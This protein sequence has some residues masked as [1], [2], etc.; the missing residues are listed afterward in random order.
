[1]QPGQASPQ[2]KLTPTDRA[3]GPVSPQTPSSSGSANPIPSINLPKGGGAIRGIGE[4]FTANPATGS[5][6]L[7]VPIHSSPGRSGFGPQ[8][9]LAYDSGN[10]NGPFGFGWSLA[11]PA[12]TRK[13]EKGLPRY[14]DSQE[15]DTFIL[16]GAEDLAPALNEAAGQ[17]SRDTTPSRTIYSR[18]YA[19]HRYRPRVEGLFARIERWI[20]VLDPQDTF[21]RS[22]SKDNITT[23]YGKTPASRIADPADASR[24]FSWLICESYDDKG[25]ATVF[26]Y[27]AENS[28]GVDLS[29]AHERNRS[30][31]T[32]ASKRYIKHVLYGNRTPYFPDLNAVGPVALPTDWCFE[33]VFDYG[34]H[35]L[36][37]PVPQEKAQLWNC[38][39]DPFSTYKA[40]FEVR[41]YRLCRRVLLFHHF[42]AEANVGLNCLVRSTDLVHSPPSPPADPSQPFYSYLLSVTQTGYSRDGAGG[43]LSN[44]L[45][46]LELQYTTAEVNETVRE[47]DAASLQNFPAGADG[48]HYRW[49]DLDGEGSPGILTEQGA[50]WYYKANLSPVNQ[51]TIGGVEVTLP[52]F[53]PVQRIAL[54]PSLADLTG[55][56]QQLLD[57][58]GDGVADLVSFEGPTPGFYE[59]TQDESWEAFVAFPSVP[60]VDWRSPNLKFVDLTG[61]GFPDLLIG[62][63]HAFSW[64]A[65]LA[66]GGFGPAQRT[67]QAFD[68]EKGPKL[69]FADGSESIFLADI[70]GDGLTDLVR[71]RNGEVCYWPNLGYGRFGAKVA[72][73]GSPR[74]DRTDLFDGRRI[75]LADIDGSGTADIIYFASGRVDL[76][77]NQS[78]NGWGAKRSLSHFPQVESLSSAM[79]VDLLGNGTVC[80]VWS[81]P[82]SSNARRPLRYIDLM[83]GQ[84]PHLLARI[85]NN[86][87]GETVVRYA[88]STKSYV[89]D[90]L[91]GTPWVTR[92]PFPVQVVEQVQT[93]DYISRNLF[94]SRYSYHHGFFDGVE[95][96]F[97]GFGRVDQFDTE[98][99]ATLANSADFPQPT[100]LDAAS[101]VP[102]VCTKTWFHTGAFFG[103]SKISKFLEHEY[104]S[105]GDSLAAIA[106]LS[107]AQAEAMLLDDTVLPS[108]IRLPDGS[109]LPY[110]LSGEELRES[111]RALRGSILRQEIYALDGS[112]ESDRPYSVSERNYTIEVLQPQGPNQFVRPSTFVMSESSSKSWAILWWPRTRP[113][114]PDPLPTLGL[115]TLLR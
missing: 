8:L 40:A 34:E 41:T 105:E 98:E 97:R 5:G 66:A 50:S 58:S 64:H 107:V 88:P 89:A 13:T 79:A 49:A 4:K 24:I 30:V 76:Y 54:R 18:Q 96:E 109:R 33:L 115:L 77:F 36:L 61:D 11:L 6:S 104:Y 100:N 81:S 86:L 44:S 84:K 99:F 95:R 73:D 35:D 83:G 55:G 1:M 60:V 23:W 108:E 106:G 3:G 51:Q 91:A 17:W 113:R 63:D 20:N 110:D 28:V 87:G 75:R 90:K 114:P 25:N 68:E 80:L 85:S 42:Q 69:V 48:S 2:E 19:I 65:S 15:S 62:E 59:R 45:P 37:N 93:Y 46:P 67:L 72:M 92:L 101:H 32:R 70:S 9:S 22:I 78:G 14:A 26:Q 21:W 57:L 12:V 10:G 27:K 94:V 31:A 39:L 112:A 103:E 7:T 111:C 16:S 38:R 82:L 53:A 47:A 71:V 74:F 102:P 43:Y 56:H 52:R 29:Q